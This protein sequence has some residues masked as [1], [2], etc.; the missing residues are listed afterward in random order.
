MSPYSAPEWRTWLKA[1]SVNSSKH[2]S[3][4]SSCG[5]WRFSTVE[6]RN[7]PFFLHSNFHY[8]WVMS[9]HSGRTTRQ[10]MLELLV[11][12][13]FSARGLAEFLS[14]PVREVEDHLTHLVKTAR[15]HSGKQFLLLPSQCQDCGFVFGKRT[16]LTPPNRCPQ[17]RSEFI[18]L[19][20]YRIL[21]KV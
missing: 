5:Y 12:Q 9:D 16:R 7:I 21:Q 1:I 2:I 6:T 4:I 3:S 13:E 20:R 11:G 17:C 15:R 8:L 19:P 18:S 14:I 10:R